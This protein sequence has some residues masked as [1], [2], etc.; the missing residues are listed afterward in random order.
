MSDQD[1]SQLESP[2]GCPIPQMSFGEIARFL[3]RG[4]EAPVQKTLAA[5]VEQCNSCREAIARI[6]ALREAGRLAMATDFAGMEMAEQEENSL[7]GAHLDEATLAAFAGH[8]LAEAE[9]RRAAKHLA[10]CHTCY[11]QLAAIAKELH[12]PATENFKT[13]A[14]ILEIMKENAGMPASS[15]KTRLENL[16]N[17][18]VDWG[19][20]FGE[21]RWPTPALAFAMGMLLML[22]IMLREKKPANLVVM[23]PLLQ[24]ASP[25]EAGHVLSGLP[26]DSLAGPDAVS[27]EIEFP[28]L[29]ESEMVFQWPPAESGAKYVVY[30]Y[31]ASGKPLFKEKETVQNRLSMPGRRFA[32]GGRYSILVMAVYQDGRAG[33]IAKMRFRVMAN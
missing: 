5:H 3:Q 32:R 20:R 26:T 25:E 16:A 2:A 22:F 28:D 18:L 30:F 7:Q 11:R 12:A 4:Y 19:R 29:P 9:R 6:E 17:R 33:V 13:P 10:E 27:A 31:E 15:I 21:W 1:E 23:M 24:T 14:E 8:G